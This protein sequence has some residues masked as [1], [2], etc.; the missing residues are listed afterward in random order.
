MNSSTVKL[1]LRE[2]KNSLGRYMAIFAIIALGAGLFVGLR[3]SKP[4]FI[5]TYNQYI[6]ETNFYDF[7]LISTLG[8]TEDDVREVLKLDGVKDAEGIVSSDFLYNTDEADNLIMVAQSIPDKINLIDLKCGRMPQKGN[9]CLADPEI[10]SEDDIGTKIKLSD[11][12]SKQQFDTFAYDEYTIVGLAETVLY[13]NIER[14]SS[15]LGNGSVEGYMYIPKDG[16]STDYFTEIYLLVDAEG[17]VY[18][19]EYNDSVEPYVKPLESFMEKRAEI[20]HD[21]IIDEAYAQ[22]DDAKAQYE[23]GLAQYTPAKAEYDRGYAEYIDKKAKTQAELDSAKAKIDSAEAMMKD[24]SILDEKQAELNNAKA[25]LD[26]GKAEYEKGLREYNIMRA[27]AYGAVES[28]IEYYENRITEKEAEIVSL[29]AELEQLNA[30]LAQAEADG[31]TITAA[32][33]RT[34]IRSTNNRISTAQNDISL[35]NS[36]LEKH[37]QDKAEA[38]AKMAPYEK[39]LSEAKAQLDSGY[40]QIE[41]GQAELDAAREMINSGSAQLEAAKKEYEQGKAAAEKG[42]AEAEAELKAGKAQ[43]DAA[44]AELDN[45]KEQLDDA[46]KQ[47]KNMDHADTYVLGRDTNAGYVCFDS[48][49]SIVHSVATVFPVF[50]FLVAA[51]VCLTTMTRM[52]DD[53]RGQ[54]GIMKALG[55]SSGAIMSKYMLYSGSATL[56]GSV[57]GIGVGS[58]VFPA[59]VWFGYGILYSFS[60]LVYTMDWTLALGVTAAN[61]AVT[62]LVTWY[63]CRRELKCAPS[64]LIRPKAPEAGKRVLLE[65]INFI[66]SE[67]NF[68]QKVSARNILRYKKRIFMMLLGVGGCTALILTA[69]GLNDTIQSVVKQQYD[70]I[71]LYDYE[72]SLAYDMTPEEQDI[73]LSDCGDNVYRA[74][75]MYRGQAEISSDTVTKRATLTV[76]DGKGLERFIWL[77]DGKDEVEYPGLNEAII[78]HNL[79]RMLGGVEIGDEMSIMTSDMGEL[80]VTVSG[81]FDNYVD[82]YIYI[83]PETCEAQWGYAPE[84]KSAL[85]NAPDG[86]DINDCATEIAK[87]DGVRTISLSADAR[88]RMSNMM[89]G[90]LIVVAA[91][92]LCAGLLA[93]IVLYNL[94]NIN[95]A[96]RIR[97]I[98]TLKV[99]G[100][101]P[102]E[103][104]DYVFRENLVLTGLGAMFGLLLGVG[105][106]AFV[107]GAIKVDMMYL[108]PRISAVSYIVSILITF[109]FAMIVNVAMRRKIDG[110]DMAGALKSVE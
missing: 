48:D 99:L 28:Q 106:H 88:D 87:V 68:M 42:F 101:Y 80:T 98:A 91:I 10:Y 47:I 58:I 32:T 11:S 96:E 5:E 20:R 60:E 3:L 22:L 16:F 83:S 31:K 82:S 34:K 24:S 12:N 46:E 54:I 52:I 37:R 61:L 8:L 85:A 38:D 65:K 86:A 70:D 4:D 13:I 72:L 78:N 90:L 104:A 95:I 109:V 23:E 17:Y 36:R 9:E 44:K 62:L 51:L 57:F 77:H 40:A 89:N 33:L 27:A 66:W 7:R 100:F 63:C 26:A 75:F 93:L 59:I 92:I 76:S 108:E 102:R 25:E 18:S 64:D 71:V 84:A 67:L 6:D 43:L 56:L 69:L 81:F 97:E 14:G 53:Q 1:T 41:A 103:A 49:T 15:T 2:I 94:T 30:E 74:M 73:F 110:I 107:I 55:Y 19:D 50:F 35:S 29:N 39:Q 45:A 79:A 105:L 21:D